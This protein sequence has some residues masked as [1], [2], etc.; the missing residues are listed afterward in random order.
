MLLLPKPLFSQFLISDGSRLL[1]LRLGNQITWSTWLTNF[2]LVQQKKKKKKKKHIPTLQM[3]Q[4]PELQI[5][6]I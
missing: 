2:Y 3:L 6:G 4:N 5:D 1:I